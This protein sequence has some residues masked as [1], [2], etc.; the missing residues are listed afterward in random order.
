MGKENLES[1]EKIVFFPKNKGGFRK[2]DWYFSCCPWEAKTELSYSAFKQNNW[3]SSQPLK[4]K[5]SSLLKMELPFK[6][7]FVF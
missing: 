2:E 3:H 4:R 1:L 6:N 5:N 7:S